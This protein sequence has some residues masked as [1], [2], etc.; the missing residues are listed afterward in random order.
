MLSLLN[1]VHFSKTKKSPVS[2]TTVSVTLVDNQ[3]W[4]GKDILGRVSPTISPTE[5][6]AFK[7]TEILLF[8]L[9]SS[10]SNQLRSLLLGHGV[11]PVEIHTYVKG[12]FVLHPKPRFDSIDVKFDVRSPGLSQKDLDEMVHKVQAQLCPVSQLL[13]NPVVIKRID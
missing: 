8:A 7:P 12:N 10:S 6:F 11:K 13:Q 1:K 3:G 5:P 9:G 4:I 2:K